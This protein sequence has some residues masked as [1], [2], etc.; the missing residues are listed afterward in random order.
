MHKN[1]TFRPRLLAEVRLS[2]EFFVPGFEIN[3]H[4]DTI[5][6][7]A[8]EDL[9]FSTF[10]RRFKGTKLSRYWT[11]SDILELFVKYDGANNG[12]LSWIQ[13][14]MIME[15]VTLESET[16]DLP[17]PD[18]RL[19]ELDGVA[20]LR[21]YLHHTLEDFNFSLPARV[22]QFIIMFLITVSTLCIV[23]ETVESLRGCA[24]LW[25]IESTI[26]II[27]TIEYLVRLGCCGRPSVFIIKPLNVID[28]ISFLPFF[29][30]ESGVINGVSGLRVIRT[31]RLS[32]MVRM[33]KLGFFADYML[34]FWET[35][36]FAKTT[37]AALG[38]VLL[39]PV[40]IFSFI[41]FSVEVCYEFTLSSVFEVVYL[42]FATMTTL[43]YGDHFPETP[44]GKFVAC[45]MVFTGLIFLTLA[46]QIV[47]N[48]FDQAYESYLN[49][50]VAKKRANAIR[51]GE[52]D[53]RSERKR[54][55]TNIT[56]ESVGEYYKQRL[57]TDFT[58]ESVVEY[59]NRTQTLEI[60][61]ALLRSSDS[62]MKKTTELSNILQLLKLQK[63]SKVVATKQIYDSYTSLQSEVSELKI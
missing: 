10:Y 2:G 27:F 30:E 61:L 9:D 34:V 42:V 14:E 11:D 13:Y 51:L 55:L 56:E 21:R 1:A 57:H 16:C 36:D 22:T 63:I 37:F 50:L 18:L 6:S 31:I 25:F 49:R 41:M 46:I 35:W 33:L 47:G 59:Y 58:E 23:L 44:A 5:N 7:D 60:Q 3:D 19:Y 24:T 29:L 26:S 62:L 28:V 48:A 12:L 15:K 45:I 20:W 38:L 8:I 40:A 17:Y 52:K 4:R 43:G 32:K 39:I 53:E 54:R